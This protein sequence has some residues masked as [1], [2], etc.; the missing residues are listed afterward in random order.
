MISL[1]EMRY[2][3]VRDKVAQDGYDV[4]W[5]PGKENLADYQSKHHPGAH[6][7]AVHTYGIYTRLIHPW[8]YQGQAEI[9]L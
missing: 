1:M 9:A 2:F 3:W 5:H 7:T 8:F 4:K 6:H